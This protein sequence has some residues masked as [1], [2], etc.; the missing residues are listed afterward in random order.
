MAL[1][2]KIE[3]DV[4]VKSSSDKFYKTLSAQVHQVPTASTKIKSID[5]HDGHWEHPGAIKQWTYVIGTLYNHQEKT[6]IILMHKI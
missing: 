4:E 3:A 1:R 6:T 2:G 5:L